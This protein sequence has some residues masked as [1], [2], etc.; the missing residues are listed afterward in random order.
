MF[1]SSSIDLDFSIPAG[2]VGSVTSRLVDLPSIV[3]VHIDRQENSSKVVVFFET[4][5]EEENIMTDVRTTMNVIRDD[6]K[7]AARKTG[8]DDQISLPV[9]P[10]FLTPN[11]GNIVGDLLKDS[12]L[13]PV[14]GR[15]WGL[16]GRLLQ[17]VRFFD[18]SFISTLSPILQNR[19][20]LPI[21]EMRFSPMIPGAYIDR[22]RLLA[23][24]PQFTFL[25]G[26]LCEDCAS[27]LLKPDFALQSAPCIK[28]YLAH[29]G[30][31]DLR[32]GIF[33]VIGDCF[34]NEQKKI[35]SMERLLSFQQ[36]E[37]VFIGPPDFLVEMKQ[38]VL[39][40][41]VEWVAGIG[42]NCVCNPANDPFF[43]ETGN[44]PDID[45]PATVKHEIRGLLPYAGRDT[46]IASFDLCGDFFTKAFAIGPQT[47][48]VWSGCIGLGLERM[49]YVFLQQYGLN[50]DLWPDPVRTGLRQATLSA[51]S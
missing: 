35:Q 37:F 46:S 28:V 38:L 21:T 3:R 16:A 50:E 49:A 45:A 12:L 20:G 5:A 13:V 27:E 40:S 14:G 43:L 18:L 4:N 6:M 25:V 9:A 22:L 7:E 34:R 32:R 44:D 39:D 33:T 51:A 2:K 1:K 47:E 30:H 31:S 24:N 23:R 8:R 19:S 42:I 48:R 26:H 29:E 15:D 17:L 11:Q 36:R 10:S 41:V